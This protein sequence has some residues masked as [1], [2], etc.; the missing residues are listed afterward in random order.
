MLLQKLFL[1]NQ[2]RGQFFNFQVL[3]KYIRRKGTGI[4]KYNSW[5]SEN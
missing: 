3:K 2:G 4:R 5:I 1:T